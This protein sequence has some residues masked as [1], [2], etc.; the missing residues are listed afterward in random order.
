MAHHEPLPIEL[1][2]NFRYV[3]ELG[4]GGQARVVLAEW[5]HEVDGQALM[6]VVAVKCYRRE[7]LKDQKRRNRVRREVCNLRKLRHPHIVL[8]KHLELT[9]QYLSVV[10]K[11]QAGGSLRDHLKTRRRLEE[12]E[13]RRYFQQLWF[14]LDFAHQQGVSNRDIKP[15][16]IL[17][18]SSECGFLVLC[19]FGLS[20]YE[21]SVMK[22]SIVGTRGYGAPELMLL[23]GRSWSKRDL[24]RMD[25]YSSGVT[26]YQ[27]LF[28]LDQWPSWTNMRLCRNYVEAMK[29]LMQETT[30]YVEFPLRDPPLSQSCL[31][32]MN[33]L[34]QPNPKVRLG[35]QEATNFEWFSE[36]LPNVQEYNAKLG[37][38]HSNGMVNMD[39]LP[40]ESKLRELIEEAGNV[41]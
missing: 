11:Y 21:H 39:H 25:A 4:Q 37:L 2:D 10:M 28:G 33:G 40:N 29:D 36:N 7:L 32:L 17:F 20:R 22:P 8:L 24:Y 5:S 38:A 12:D 27:M 18:N 1:P 26:L 6:E 14:A 23:T 16:N 41:P 9:P 15:D 19:D 13:A 3:R 34:L 31:D 30:K 35:L